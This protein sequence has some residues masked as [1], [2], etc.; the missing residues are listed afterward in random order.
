MTPDSPR[1]DLPL[2]LLSAFAASAFGAALLAAP[3]AQAAPKGIE[4]SQAW[5]RPAVAG[6]TGV[7][8][9]VIA[10]HAAKAD[11][12]TAATTPL[13][14]RVEMHAMSMANGIMSMSKVDRVA[15]PGGGQAEFGPGG[16]HLMMVGLTRTLS[17]GERVPVTLT[18][19]SGAKVQSNLIVGL[20]PPKS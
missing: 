8:Y 18:F 16:Y 11:A 6:T 4:I 17:V 19:A 14:A 15:V 10:N 5:S 3:P 1:R 20:T 9:L 12:V 13:A 7:G 2:K